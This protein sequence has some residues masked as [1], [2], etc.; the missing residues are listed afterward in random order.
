M[1][2]TL[3]CSQLGLVA[4]VWLFRMLPWAWPGARVTAPSPLPSLTLP[5][6]KRR[7]EPTL[8]AGLT[9]KPHCDACE[10]VNAPP[11]TPLP[12]RHPASS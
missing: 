11:R 2:P 5:R 8:F 3:F 7:G 9:R 1:V 4:L 12:P 10:P 6:R